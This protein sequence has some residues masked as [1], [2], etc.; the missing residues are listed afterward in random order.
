M[1]TL[2]EK[3]SGVTILSLEG[4]AGEIRNKGT[5]PMDWRNSLNMYVVIQGGNSSM[6]HV[7]GGGWK[8]RLI[9]FTVKVR[10]HKDMDVADELD[11]A[12]IELSDDNLNFKLKGI[13]YAH[14][15]KDLMTL[16]T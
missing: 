16:M 7:C 6:N 13:K 10:C 8:F 9:T 14:D 11:S 1:G 15:K 12:S 3:L 4:E 5:L 2:M